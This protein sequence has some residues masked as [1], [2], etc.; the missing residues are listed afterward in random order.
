MQ[1]KTILVTGTTKGIGKAISIKLLEEGYQVI[2]IARG[3]SNIDHP[4]YFHYRIDLAELASLPLHL[5][6]LLKDFPDLQGLVCNAGRGHFGHLEELSFEHIQETVQLNFLSHVCLVKMCLPRFKK[7]GNGDL[8]FIGSEAALSGKKKGSIYC[9]TKFAIRGFAQALREECATDDVRITLIN[10]GMVK[11][12]FF[13]QLSFKPG[14]EATE[15]ILPEDIAETV[16][17]VLS[18]RNGTVFDEINLSPQKKR[19]IF[20]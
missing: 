8:I 5:K 1:K 18:A 7:Q 16:S 13:D 19:I 14:P 12:E 10:P 6:S 20:S 3:L 17:L 2:G 9:A 15:H 4:S 11:T